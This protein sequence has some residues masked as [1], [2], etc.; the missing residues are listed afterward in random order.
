MENKLLNIKEF[1][2][3]RN[4]YNSIT[5]EELKEFQHHRI[6]KMEFLERMTGFGSNRACT[7][8]TATREKN[9]GYLSCNLCVW[10]I[11]N[12]DNLIYPCTEHKAEKTYMAIDESTMIKELHTAYRNRAKLMTK[13][14]KQ[15][16]LE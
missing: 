12:G 13:V 2:A 1:I 14:I 4:R 9:N 11:Y 8:C 6:S 15:L 5:E 3:L 16:K 7:L 10:H